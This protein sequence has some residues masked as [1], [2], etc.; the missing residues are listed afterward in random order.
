MK[1]LCSV[2]EVSLM[3][4]EILDST[5]SHKYI[6]ST[7]AISLINTLLQIK[8]QGSNKN[9]LKLRKGTKIKTL[10]HFIVYKYVGVINKPRLTKD[11]PP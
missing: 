1:C 3:Y 2:M 11:M 8:F 7:Y 4:V 6:K 9:N 5:I 10:L